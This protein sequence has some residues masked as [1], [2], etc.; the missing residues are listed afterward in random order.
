MREYAGDILHFDERLPRLSRFSVF[1]MFL[2]RDL[3]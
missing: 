3:P 2:Y 1:P